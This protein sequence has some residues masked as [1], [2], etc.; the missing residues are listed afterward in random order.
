MKLFVNGATGKQE[1]DFPKGK[2]MNPMEVVVQMYDGLVTDYPFDKHN[3]Y[4]EMY[5]VPGKPEKEEH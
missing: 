2:K 5:F 3:A 4:L 1:T